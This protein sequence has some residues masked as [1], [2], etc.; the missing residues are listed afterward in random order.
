MKAT[1]V[2]RQADEQVLHDNYLQTTCR[3]KSLQAHRVLKT[4]REYSS[5]GMEPEQLRYL[6]K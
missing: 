6:V 4:S 3:L 2:Q 5:A 1:V